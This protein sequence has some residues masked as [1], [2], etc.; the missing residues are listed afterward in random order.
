MHRKELMQSL[1]LG[2][3]KTYNLFH[4][5][6][7][8]PDTV[9]NVSKKDADSASAGYDALIKLRRLHVGL[10][11]A[12]RNAYGWKNLDLEHDFHEVETLPENDRVRYTVSPTAAARC[13]SACSPRIMP[14]PGLRRRGWSPSPSAMNGGACPK[15]RYSKSSKASPDARDRIYLDRGWG[16]FTNLRSVRTHS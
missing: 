11:L 12:V 13:S 14:G 15:P 5:R 6:D 16:P 7:L 9:A 3:T 2:L 10:D 8:S 4:A 1:C